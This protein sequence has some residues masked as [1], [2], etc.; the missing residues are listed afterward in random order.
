ME[1]D[2]NLGLLSIV[3]VGFKQTKW[4]NKSVILL[5]DYHILIKNYEVSKKKKK[6]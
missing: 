5:E 4:L 1:A 6:S 3:G 2:L